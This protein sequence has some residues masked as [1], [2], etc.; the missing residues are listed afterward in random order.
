[1]KRLDFQPLFLI[2]TKIAR[3]FKENMIDY[4]GRKGVVIMNK[5]AIIGTGWISSSFVEAVQQTNS[6]EVVSVYSRTLEKA[7][8]FATKH[9]IPSWTNQW[10]DFLL[11]NWDVVYIGS[12]N[13]THCDYSKQ[14]LEHLKN[15]I[16]EKPSFI[17]V[18]EWDEVH[19]LAVEK[20]LFVM[21]AIRHYYEPAFQEI[22]KFIAPRMNE[23][24]G[25]VLSYAKYSS[26]YDAFLK[27]EVAS[28][29]SLASGGGALMDLGV[30]PIYNAISW[31]GMPVNVHYQ[32]RK[33]ENQ[34]DG[35]GI[36]SLSYPTFDVTIFVGKVLNVCLPQEIYFGKETLQ[37]NDCQEIKEVKTLYMS[38]VQ[39]TKE[40][41]LRKNPLE[42][43][44][45]AFENILKRSP[46][47]LV[48]YE[49]SKI[50]SRNVLE[51]IEAL[52]NSA[53][54]TFN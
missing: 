16:V 37:I 29:F 54:I 47:S 1:M 15:I 3:D 36:V 9:Q 8:E 21:E 44:A 2:A 40:Y 41:E 31:F 23:V 4:P 5:L 52:R 28:S 50:I 45:I 35:Q 17:S 13:H 22:G 38:E 53:G 25:A 18:E 34:A 19:Q 26:K 30:Y 27:G 46:E 39:E 12:P 11:E 48:Q 33:L 6:F 51:V 49:Q 24:K 7:E 32:A 43:E 20:N 10:N 42:W 14:L